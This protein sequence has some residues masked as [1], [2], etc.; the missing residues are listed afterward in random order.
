M[1]TVT[2]RG[3]GLARGGSRGPRQATAAGW[4]SL[5]GGTVAGASSRR[6]RLGSVA[7]VRG[8]GRHPAIR[9]ITFD[10]VRL[11]VLLLTVPVRS[12]GVSRLGLHQLR[13]WR[14]P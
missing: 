3:R 6:M 13:A 4:P 1:M 12:Y 8:G 9:R 14:E 7:G 10:G 11:V 5:V 2:R